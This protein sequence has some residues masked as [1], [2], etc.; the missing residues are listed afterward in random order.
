MS[1]YDFLSAN[2]NIRSA[3]DWP[4]LQDTLSHDPPY[5]FGEW[6]PGGVLC[7]IAGKFTLSENWTSLLLPSRAYHQLVLFFEGRN[8]SSA[9]ETL[10]VKTTQ[11]VAIDSFYSNQPQALVCNFSLPVS[12]VSL[13]LKKGVTPKSAR[14]AASFSGLL[15]SASEQG[16]SN[17]DSRSL[18]LKKTRED[19]LH[20]SESESAWFCRNL[21]KF[22]GV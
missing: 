19:V 9:L 8:L 12:G 14:V 18:W 10:E 7:P 13:R 17:A 6:Q 3:T 11:R 5:L 20:L 15:C 2:P 22:L 16:S 4:K 1:L 21:G